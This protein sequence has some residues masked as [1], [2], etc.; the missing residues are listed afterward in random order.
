MGFTPKKDASPIPP[1]AKGE[2]NKWAKKYFDY[3]QGDGE[4]YA[5]ELAKLVAKYNGGGYPGVEPIESEGVSRET[6]NITL[7][8]AELQKMLGEVE[9]RIEAK[10]LKT[11]PQVAGG[12]G[13]LKEIF[14]DLAE[15]LNPNKGQR[16]RAKFEAQIDREDYLD[17]PVVFFTYYNTYAIHSEMR[18]SHEVKTP[19]GRPIRFSNISGHV[20]GGSKNGKQT[21]Q[22]SA[23]QIQTKKELDWMLASPKYNV[24]FFR[25]IK[26][27]QNIDPHKAS[28]LAEALTEI[29]GFTEY[30]VMQ[31][32]ISAGVPPSTDV[33]HMRKALI[34]LIANQNLDIE[35]AVSMGAASTA[36]ATREATIKR[37]ASQ[38][39]GVRVLS[40]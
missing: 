22:I 39:T 28:K 14:A 23:A 2:S 4:I 25:Q 33:E 26:D 36:D 10:L 18:Y 21:V 29:S 17:E 11:S 6:D 1:C 16:F 8:R 24:V 34:E 30:Q 7:S 13:E 15:Q 40:Y 35:R 38:A 9:T 31:R 5:K 37:G 3:E 19:Y 27:V 12:N 20:T 32:A